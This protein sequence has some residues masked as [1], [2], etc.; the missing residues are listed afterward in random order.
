MKTPT[1]KN[2]FWPIV[3]LVV[4]GSILYVN[5]LNAPFHFDDKSNIYNPSLKMETLNAEQFRAT[6]FGSTL[7]ARPI[8]NLSFAFNY[9]VG[10]YRVQGYHLVNI[11]IHICTGI[12]LY[13]LL[14]VTLNLAVNKRNYA[15]GSAIA[16]MTAFI[17]IA[18]PVAT[19]SVTYI[20]Q[21]MNSMAAMFFVLA[22]LL[23][24]VGRER[25]VAMTK[26]KSSLPI[27]VWFFASCISGLLAIGSKE[28]AA[29]IPLFIFLYEWY[30]FQDLQWK[31]MKKK[32]YWLIGI[33]FVIWCLTYAYTNGQIIERIFNNCNGRDFSTME[34]VLTQFRVV[35][36]YITLVFY[37]NPD[38]LA[39]DYDFPLSISL[40]SP[41]S[42]LYSF[43]TI[44][45]LVGFAILSARR[46]RLVS[47]C[48]LWFFGNL[49]IESSVICLEIIF[50]HRTYLPSMFLILLFVA[51]VYRF[52]HNTALVSVALVLA[53]IFL[54]YWT[55]E[56]NKV[57]Q[58]S[59]ALWSD[60]AS[61]HPNKARTH[62]SLA[63]TFAELGELTLAEKEYRQALALYKQSVVL[64]PSIAIAHNNLAILLLRQGRMK[65]AEFH[66]Q[67]AIRIKPEYVEALVNLGEL[68]REQ[69]L[70]EKAI[71]H[72]QEALR[73]VP[74]NGVVN[75]NL[76]NALLRSNR[77]D[78]ALPYLQK[79]LSNS[80]HDHEILLD[81]GEALAVLGRIDDA[82]HAY[83]E[84]LKKDRTNA[85]AHYHLAL[86]LKMNGFEQEA[87]THYREADRLLRYPTDIKYDF[88][89]LLFRLGELQ[90]AEKSYKEFLGLSTSL[91]KAYNNLG[92]V[93]VHQGRYMEAVQQFQA[94]LN[95]EPSLGFAADN[96]RLAQE[97]QA[98]MKGGKR[99]S[100]GE[101][102]EQ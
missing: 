9:F 57:W 87:L 4:T 65:E 96:M 45:A 36:I 13:L 55:F 11:G 95:V 66:L 31:W 24:A 51:M 2:H 71:N 93:L 69:G 89:N 44:V 67:E 22:M 37:P 14:Q 6:L 70:Y 54:G 83:R 41:I 19:Q 53:S 18:H 15:N 86:L 47:F 101:K 74:E 38:R 91:A 61:K 59:L 39:L 90:E 43:L 3:L 82:I 48:I 29:T 40:L 17:W 63:V 76:G 99:E 35:I 92:L 98:L 49:V 16:L 10:R 100:M 52:V 62:G 32:M 97:Q 94:A 88:G 23:Y 68:L 50:E 80:S 84:I 20:V 26:G 5:T 85:S 64:D 81:L 27:W 42:T 102:E 8:S 56:R 12:F 25:H 58:T 30:F 33:F 46:E 7:Q 79:A 28:I 1:I 73:F 21:R 78:T 72:F 77:I 34:R 60:S 75:K